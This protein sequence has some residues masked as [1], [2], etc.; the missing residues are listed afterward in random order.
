MLLSGAIAIVDVAGAC[1]K[2][3]IDIGMGAVG[4]SL[5]AYLELATALAH[6]SGCVGL[7]GKC[8]LDYALRPCY[9]KALSCRLKGTGSMNFKKLNFKSFT[10]CKIVSLYAITSTLHNCF[11]LLF[12][13]PALHDKLYWRQYHRQ[14]INCFRYFLPSLVVMNKQKHKF[15]RLTFDR[16]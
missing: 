10:V 1:T 16:F 11:L 3:G 8:N 15:E 9:Y 7:G 6:V 14:L 12:A 2:L 13:V 4:C 5:E